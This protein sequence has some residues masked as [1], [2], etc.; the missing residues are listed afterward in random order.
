MWYQGYITKQEP[1]PKR[2]AA[3]KDMPSPDNIASLQRFLGLANYN[4]VFIQSMY[5][6]VAPLNELLKKDKPKDWTSECQEV[7]VKHSYRQ[8]Y[9]SHITTQTW[10][11]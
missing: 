2:T 4:Q 9:F 1:D 6:L 8:T 11:S 10:K 7:F 3:I 5:G